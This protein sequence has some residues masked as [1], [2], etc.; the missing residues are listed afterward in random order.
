MSPETSEKKKMAT[1]LVQL[2]QKTRSE[3]FEYTIHQC[4]KADVGRFGSSRK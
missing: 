1:S 2:E 3:V 4:L